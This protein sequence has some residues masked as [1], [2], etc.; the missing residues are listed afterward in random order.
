[1]IC[2]SAMQK[3][4]RGFVFALRSTFTIFAKLKKQIGKN[5]Y[6]KVSNLPLCL[7]GIVV[8]GVVYH[9]VVACRT[10][11]FHGGVRYCRL[12]CGGIRSIV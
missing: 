6:D 3:T 12:G 4:K 9:I 5:C 10:C 2:V 1:M 8:G 11:R 7:C